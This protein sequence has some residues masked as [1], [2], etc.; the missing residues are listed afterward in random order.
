MLVDGGSHL[1]ISR[2]VLRRTRKRV[3]P[4]HIACKRR[5]SKPA[6]TLLLFPRPAHYTVRPP[7]WLLTIYR[8]SPRHTRVCWMR[9]GRCNLI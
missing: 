1:L 5:L 3:N 2:C 8:R 4:E 7:R 9:R 6:L